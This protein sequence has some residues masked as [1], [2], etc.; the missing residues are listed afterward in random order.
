MSL[1]ER[2]QNDNTMDFEEYTARQ[3]QLSRKIGKLKNEITTHPDYTDS[4]R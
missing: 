1:V 3:E 2:F 4:R